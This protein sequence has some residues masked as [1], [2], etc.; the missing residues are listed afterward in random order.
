MSE[1]TTGDVPFRPV[2][3]DEEAWR[4]ALQNP[5]MLARLRKSIEA[6][7][8][9]EQPIPATELMEGLRTRHASD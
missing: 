4:R 7:L 5:E 2:P 6:R 8:R 1:P 3:V 9:G